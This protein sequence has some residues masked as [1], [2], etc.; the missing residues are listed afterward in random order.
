MSFTRRQKPWLDSETRGWWFAISH[1]FSMG[2]NCC[3]RSFS[4]RA[5]IGSSPV[6][7]FSRDS[8]KCAFLSGSGA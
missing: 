2:R 3:S 5:T 8:E 4:V 6:I 1:S 7:C